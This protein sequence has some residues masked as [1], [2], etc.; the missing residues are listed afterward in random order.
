MF[1]EVTTTVTPLQ[2]HYTSTSK[3]WEMKTAVQF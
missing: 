3:T 2:I 1:V